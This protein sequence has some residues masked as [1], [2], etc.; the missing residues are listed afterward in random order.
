MLLNTLRGTGQPPVKTQRIVGSPVSAVL[1]LRNSVADPLA[2]LEPFLPG[3]G[4]PFYF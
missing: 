2:Q 1:R 3:E 4:M